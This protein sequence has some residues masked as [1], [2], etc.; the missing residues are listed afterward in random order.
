MKYSDNT[1]TLR[2][3]KILVEKFVKD[4]KWGK[5]HIPRNLAKS[6]CIESAELLEIF[7]WDTLDGPVT[8]EGV[9]MMQLEEELADV[10]I[11]CISMANATE[12]DLAKAISDKLRK[13]ELKYPATN[14]KK[15]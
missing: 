13:N 9:R 3:M 14:Q 10:L 15:T 2:D 1:S 6:I 12:V 11:Y 7:Q 5:Y 4:R 8:N